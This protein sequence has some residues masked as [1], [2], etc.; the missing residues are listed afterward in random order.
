MKYAR[1]PGWFYRLAPGDRIS[2]LA[3][4]RLQVRTGAHPRRRSGNRLS[5]GGRL[6]PAVALDGSTS[7]DE[8]FALL[9]EVA[10]DG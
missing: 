3:L 8:V 7:A 1:D 9:Q 4:E 5:T 10:A 2:I 6:S